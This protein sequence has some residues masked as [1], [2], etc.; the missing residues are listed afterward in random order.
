MSRVTLD[1]HPCS[2]GL[3]CRDM[4]F[5]RHQLSLPRPLFTPM[6]LTHRGQP[7]PHQPRPGRAA[8]PW[9]G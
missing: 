6:R 3:R 9:P 8:V 7:P 4:H 1:D 2:V 5:F